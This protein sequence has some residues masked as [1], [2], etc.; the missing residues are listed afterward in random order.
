LRQLSP[1]PT[2]T[3]SFTETRR[4]LVQRFPFCLF[5]RLDGDGVILIA[6]LHAARD[7]KLGR[8]RFED[9]AR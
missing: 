7:P 8:S 4:V 3:P 5:Y 2:P 9:E 6:C 1:S